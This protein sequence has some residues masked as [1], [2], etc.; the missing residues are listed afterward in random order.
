V[1]VCVYK[2][3]NVCVCVLWCTQSNDEDEK[4][5]TLE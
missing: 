3:E 5:C 4:T 2:K 1:C